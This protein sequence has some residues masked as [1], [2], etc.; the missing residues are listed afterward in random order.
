MPLTGDASDSRP[1]GPAPLLTAVRLLAA[2]EVY[3]L[4]WLGRDL[5]VESTYG[6]L[7]DFVGIG[8][9]VSDHIYALVGLESEIAGL[10]D[11]PGEVIELPE[12][13]LVT[14]TGRRPRANLS[15]S[16]SPEAAAFILLVARTGSRSDLEI[17]LVAQMRARLMAE[18]ELAAKTRQ[19]QRV[20]GELGR[21][22][23]DLE[24]YASIISHD[25]QSP[26][27][28]LRYMVDDL[29]A[30][31]DTDAAGDVPRLLDSM[32]AQSRRM[33][34][35]LSALLEYSAVTRKADAIELV[36]TAALVRTIVS[37]ID[38][39]RGF[40]VAIAGDWPHVATL[41]ALLDL[42]LRNLI[43]NA[44]KHHDR[45]AGIINV[46]AL[47]DGA[48]LIITI[49]DDGPGIR[50]DR[51]QDIFLPFRKLAASDASSG[52]GM[53]LALVRRAVEGMGGQIS[54][55]GAAPDGRGAVFTVHWPL[56]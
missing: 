8:E 17:E 44:V 15:V 19:L 40:R 31:L 51:R 35:M 50:P 37:S 7:V 22:N 38:I 4:V 18:S 30:A 20:N 55:A 21:A 14:A 53:G 10:Q 56:R 25:L 34:G 52:Q 2:R 43:D 12:V 46:T 26:M 39:P 9:P 6:K 49:A 29:E 42:V 28:A 16:W 3:G 45:E 23:A 32:R 41:A 27:R 1:P 13:T 47:N 48:A 11:R 36:D 54:V 33:T 24:A 5:V